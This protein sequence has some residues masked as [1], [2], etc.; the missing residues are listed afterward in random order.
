MRDAGANGTGT[1][2]P[3][4]SHLLF[5]R[6]TKD[7][8]PNLGTNWEQSHPNTRENERAGPTRKQDE[9]TR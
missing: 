7:L 1:R 8:H 9:S 3:S 6:A 5:R 4:V 2:H